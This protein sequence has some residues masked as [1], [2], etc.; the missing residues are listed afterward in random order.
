MNTYEYH[1][2]TASSQ[3]GENTCKYHFNSQPDAPSPQKRKRDHWEDESSTDH[4]KIKFK[5]INDPGT[6]TNQ[7]P[8]RSLT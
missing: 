7:L 1:S 6:Y 2:F 3:A 5:A 4:D 8:P